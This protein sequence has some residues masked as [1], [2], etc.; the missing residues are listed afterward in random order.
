MN[1]AFLK[2]FF[3]FSVATSMLSAVA[4]RFGWYPQEISAWGTME[5]FTQYSNQALYFLPEN[6]MWVLA[7]I[8]TIIEIIGGI[9]LLLGYKTKFMAGLSAFILA[10]FAVSMSIGFGVKSI[11]DY[12]VLNAVS[13]ALAILLIKE[14]PF[15]LDNLLAKK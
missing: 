13:A 10:V 1:L 8:A 7:W 4:D 3:R 12:S 11:M 5:A 9:G 15:E 14:K 6:V 2:I